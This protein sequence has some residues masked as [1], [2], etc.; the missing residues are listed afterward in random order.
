MSE[1]LK[2]YSKVIVATLVLSILV[3]CG[4]NNIPKQQLE[5]SDRHTSESIAAI[6]NSEGTA[7]VKVVLFLTAIGVFTT[8]IYGLFIEKKPQA[9]KAKAEKLL[10]PMENVVG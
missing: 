10:Q 9:A 2:H 6:P 5:G 3:G 1:K 7:G 4:K 8:I